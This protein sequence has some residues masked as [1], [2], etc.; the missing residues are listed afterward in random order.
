MNDKKLKILGELL[1]SDTGFGI[2]EL[3]SRNELYLAEITNIMHITTPNTIYHIKKLK[4]L[5]LITIIEKP[6]VKPNLYKFYSMDPK[7]LE[8]LRGLLD[9]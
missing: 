7:K 1:A 3:L 2:I 8:E 9:N 5:G 4:M 6:L